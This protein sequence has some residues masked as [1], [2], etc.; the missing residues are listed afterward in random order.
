M[1]LNENEKLLAE[2][3]DSMLDAGDGLGLSSHKSDL[4]RLGE[5]ERGSEY[6]HGQIEEMFHHKA[7]DLTHHDG[8]C[9]A[10]AKIHSYK[11]IDDP[12]F[13]AAM[14][15]ELTAQGIP[16]EERDKA[17]ELVP[18]IIEQLHSENSSRSEQDA[19]WS[20]HLDEITKSNRDGEVED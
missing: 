19:G 16:A 15:K 20:P 13:E 6:L 3:F 2:A 18:S 5:E 9:A 11:Y 12:T 8:V 17:I 7:A 1:Q 10:F 14:H 4:K